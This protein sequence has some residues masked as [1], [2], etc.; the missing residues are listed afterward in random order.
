MP[1]VASACLLGLG[2]GA[3]FGPV[4]VEITKVGLVGRSEEA[5]PLAIGAWSGDAVLL[6]VLATIFAGASEVG[7]INTDHVWVRILAA[8][9]IV[10]IA[11]KSLYQG[12]AF[13]AADNAQGHVAAVASKGVLLST[14]SPYGILLWSGMAAAVVSSD[15]DVAYAAAILIGDGA[16]FVFWLS[17][18]RI[19]RKRMSTRAV[20]PIHFVANGALLALAALLVIA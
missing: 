12:P 11:A 17:V 8:A 2:A 7:A 5:R 4:N 1:L 10:V 16:W 15:H 14:L 20:R 18:L 19:A 3:S 9:A 13:E 6:I